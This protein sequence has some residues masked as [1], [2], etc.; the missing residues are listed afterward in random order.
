MP[1]FEY[2]CTACGNEFEELVFGDKVPPCP[3]CKAQQT[4]K[5]M[6]RCRHK[7]GGS[8]GFDGPA[9][10][11]GGSKCGGCSGGSCSTCH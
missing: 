5:L 3:R 1:I 10:A 2:R 6:S 11:A 9:P 7:S 4:E 8:A